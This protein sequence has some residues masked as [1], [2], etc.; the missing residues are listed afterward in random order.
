M[1]YIYLHSSTMISDC[2]LTQFVIDHYHYY[3]RVV[4]LCVQFLEAAAVNLYFCELVDHFQ[5]LLQG[6]KLRSEAYCCLTIPIPRLAIKQI[7]IW[8]ALDG[9]FFSHFQPLYLHYYT[10]LIMFPP[11]F[12][13]CTLYICILEL[14]HRATQVAKSFF[15]CIPYRITENVKLSSA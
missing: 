3:Y 4:V 2:I 8:K 9:T 13:T 10:A 11:L 7:P 6:Q 5:H 14:P 12:H 15:I 1:S